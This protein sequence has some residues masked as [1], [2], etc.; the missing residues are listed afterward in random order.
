MDASCD[1]GVAVA[2]SMPAAGRPRSQPP[3]DAALARAVQD[4]SEDAAALLVRRHWERAHRTAYLILHDAAT[5]EDVCQEAMLA[6]I[7]GIGGF[8]ARRPFGPWLHR[9]VANRA[10]DALRARATRSEMPGVEPPAQSAPDIGGDHTLEALAVL[11]EIDRAIVVLR[12]LLDYNS[13]EIGRMLEL[14]AATVHTRLRRALAQL[15]GEL[16]GEGS[17]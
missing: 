6:A 3:D 12:H 2:R 11:D 8:D 9:I 17:R 1:D 4:G 10:L 5:A 15:R 16:G 13:R 7:R 14:P